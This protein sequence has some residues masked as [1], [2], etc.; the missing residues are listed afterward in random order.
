MQLQL[1]PVQLTVQFEPW[2]H[3]VS[4]WPPTQSTTHVAP[5]GHVVWQ[6]PPRHLT[7]HF[8]ALVQVVVQF[9]L[10]QLSVQ[11]LP[12]AQSV[13]HGVPSS[14]HLRSHVPP[15]GHEHV[16]PLHEPA[17]PE[18]DDGESLPPSLGVGVVVLLG[19]SVKS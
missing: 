16:V 4:Q 8:A 13:V 5:A 6:L 15:L 3:V 1:P 10:K 17:P 12:V 9:P 11:S 14:P 18:E 2:S 19:P 7:A